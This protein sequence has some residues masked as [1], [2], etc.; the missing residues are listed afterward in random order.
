M[1]K[2]SLEFR[3]ITE[4]DCKQKFYT[5]EKKFDFDKHG[6]CIP[7]SF[8]LDR[9][10]SG[11]YQS[12]VLEENGEI[13]GVLCIKFIGKIWMHLSRIGVQ[14]KLIGDGY[15]YYLHFLMLKNI[16]EKKGI[17]AVSTD[18]HERYFNW[19]TGRGYKKIF[20]FKDSHWGKSAIMLLRIG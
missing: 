6:N 18:V 4:C 3:R 10:C 5:G 7:L 14:E 20:D 1:K 12:Y 16:V 11:E 8:Y 19:F 9:D 13:V 2:K 15:G 17:K